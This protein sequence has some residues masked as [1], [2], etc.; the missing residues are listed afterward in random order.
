[1]TIPVTILFAMLAGLSI[2]KTAPLATA[3]ARR[4]MQPGVLRHAGPRGE[5]AA[6]QGRQRVRFY[7][8]YR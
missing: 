3:P 8:P 5:P 6:R 7:Q 1:M 2:L 4:C